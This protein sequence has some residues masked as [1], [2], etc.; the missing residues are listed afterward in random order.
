MTDGRNNRQ[1]KVIPFL[2]R[3]TKDRLENLNSIINTAKILTPNGFEN[4][5][6]DASVWVI[7]S[8]RLTRLTGKNTNSVKFN[9]TLPPKLGGKP[10][11]DSWAELAKSLLVLRFHRNHQAA[12]N[13]RNFITAI[14]Y[15][16]YFAS[17][18]GREIHTITREVLDKACERISKDYSDSTAYNL[19]KAVA[20]F[21]GHCDSNGL[22]LS[23]LQY[24]YTGMKRPK[25]TSGVE[26]VRLDDP[27]ALKT[28]N[29]KLLEPLVFKVLG[30]L[31]LS[32]PKNHKYRFYVLLLTF[33]A[34]VGRRFSEISLLPNQTLKSDK[35]GAYYIEYFP[36]KP[37]KG[38]TFTPKR[39][40]YL[41]SA[42]V[43]IVEDVLIE[44]KELCKSARKT[45]EVMHR[46]KTANLNFL[47]DVDDSERLYKSDLADLNIPES[48]LDSRGGIRVNGY[49]FEDNKN[50]SVKGN[51]T[52]YT[53]KE[54]V[55]AYCS[56]DYSKAFTKRIHL[57]QERQEYFLKDLLLVR[58]Q[59]LSS[60]R[61]SHWIATQCTHSMMTTFLRYLPE[62][63]M[64]FASSS[65]EVDFTSHHFRHTINTLLDEGGLTD[66][67]QTEWFGRTNPKDTKAY[68]NTSPEKRAL[69]LKE[70]IKKGKVGGKFA[71][72][73]MALPVTVQDAVLNARIKAVHDVGTGVC[74]HSFS[75]TPCPRHLQCSAECD[76]YA[77]AKDDKGR[78]EEQ[79]RQLALTTLARET[80]QNK[81]ESTKPKKSKDWLIHNDKKIKTLTKQLEDN[82]VVEFDPKEY[83]KAISNGK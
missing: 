56:K 45:A 49:A 79:K 12:P 5:D 23:S 65:L 31:Y 55:V 81:A 8:G 59:G 24:R 4:V 11:L 27:E 62:L 63:S 6:R 54:G 48:L 43:P 77:W 64:Q 36:R 69:L 2:N 39:K 72:H 80:A 21:A 15:I 34:C 58:H 70:A 16:S 42:T 35:K 52:Y 68:Q 26:R 51:P 29:D 75:Q 60:G 1:A 71:E 40:L 19:H 37:S 3:I 46:Q 28:K 7:S 25:S 10:L 20:E 32:V 83:L 74:F 17:S 33:L 18:L 47:V 66:L 22:C 13:Q 78:I 57:D 30:E 76:D 82:G 73:V 50:L 9:F 44:L 61:Y 14:A 53:N 41:L 38:D 67:L